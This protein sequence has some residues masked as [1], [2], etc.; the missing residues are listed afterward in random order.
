MHRKHNYSTLRQLVQMMMNELCCLFSPARHLFVEEWSPVEGPVFVAQ[1]ALSGP[2]TAHES[3]SVHR[4]FIDSDTGDRWR[5]NDQKLR[6]Y[7]ISRE[8]PSAFEYAS[9]ED[10]HSVDARTVWVVVCL[11]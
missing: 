9:S 4:A 5:L 7:F 6:N 1:Q 2:H 8:C 11:V 10:T 3:A